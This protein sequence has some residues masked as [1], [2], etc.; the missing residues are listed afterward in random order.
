M[1]HTIKYIHRK[2]LQVVRLVKTL[3]LPDIICSDLVSV[4]GELTSMARKPVST[5]MAISIL[6]AVYR[7]HMSEPCA[8]DALR[9][10]LSSAEIMP[11]EEFERVWDGELRHKHPKETKKPPQS[12]PQQKSQNPKGSKSKN[13]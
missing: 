12:R 5:A 11:P 7:A 8:R 3:N 10:R 9:Q 13:K 1:L 6:I 4:S 2:N